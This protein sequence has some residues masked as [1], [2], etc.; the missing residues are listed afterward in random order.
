[1]PGRTVIQSPNNFMKVV[2]VQG[3]IQPDV[4]HPKFTER[5]LLRLLQHG[6]VEQQRAE[7]RLTCWAM[8]LIEITSESSW[9]AEPQFRIVSEQGWC[10]ST[11]WVVPSLQRQAVPGPRDLSPGLVFGEL[12]LLEDEA[13]WPHASQTLIPKPLW[14]KVACVG[15]MVHCQTAWADPMAR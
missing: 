7:N 4:Y 10:T 14:L 2:T 8:G 11:L 6:L 5:L 12:D 3:K 9:L 13:E 15:E 1:M